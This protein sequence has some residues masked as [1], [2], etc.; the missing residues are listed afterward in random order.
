MVARLPILVTAVPLLLG[1]CDQQLGAFAKPQGDT[2]ADSGTW[3]GTDT[4][5]GDDVDPNDLDGD[6]VTTAEGD[7][8]DTDLRIGPGLPEREDNEKDDD[9]DGRIDEEWDGVAVAYVSG[10]GTGQILELSR[11]GKIAETID[12]DGGCAPTFLAYLPNETGWLVNNGFAT[13]VTVDR[14]GTCTELADFSETD[15]GVYGITL[16]LD[17]TY[18]ATTVDS[19][20][21]IATSGTVTTLA[22]WDPETEMLAV[23]L[24][25]DPKTGQ[26]GIFDYLGGFATYDATDGF[27]IQIQADFSNPA[28]K[29]FSGA[30][31]DGGSWYVPAQDLET[32]TYGVYGYDDAKKTWTKSDEWHDE[33]WAPYMLTVDGDDPEHPDYYVTA[34]AG[35]YQTVWRIVGG[36]NAALNFY[37]SE[38]TEPGTFY[39]IA[40]HE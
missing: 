30:H 36:T 40:A 11:S 18:Y 20:V 15:Y 14:S 38:G 13:V 3:H 9:C 29:T 31:R 8:D 25:T 24:A 27:V 35:W 2:A 23:G 21:S 28:L 12:T 19:L 34:T 33:D 7:C 32:G 6:G 5:T 10:A 17:G 39:G 4:D 16:G 26:I 1:G 37:V 22:S